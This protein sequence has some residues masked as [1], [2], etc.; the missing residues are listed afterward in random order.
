MTFSTTEIL[1]E[2]QKSTTKVRAGNGGCVT[3]SMI[4]RQQHPVEFTKI[5]KLGNFVIKR[6][7]GFMVRRI[8]KI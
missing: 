2:F 1:E 3:K 7:V 5:K 8:R 6:P 4:N